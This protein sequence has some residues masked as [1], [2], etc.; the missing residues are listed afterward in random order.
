MRWNGRGGKG[1]TS[2]PQFPIAVHSSGRYL[3]QADGRPFLIIGESAWGLIVRLTE[4]QV[5][6]YIADRKSRGF[7]CAM[8]M[9]IAKHVFIQ[10]GSSTNQN[11]DNPFTGTALIPAN[12]NAAYFT[13]A[14]LVVR[15]FREAGMVL[16][17]A[18]CYSGFDGPSTTEGWWPDLTS[19]SVATNWGNWFGNRYKNEPHVIWLGGGDYTPAAGSETTRANALEQA[20]LDA[21]A[22]QLHT[23]HNSRGVG[24]YQKW[25]GLPSWLTLGNIYTDEGV[26]YPIHDEAATEYARSPAKP[27]FLIEDRYA[28]EGGISDSACI[29]QKWQAILSGACG[30]LIGTAAI[31]KFESGYSSEF[32]SVANQGMTHLK[33]LLVDSGYDWTTLVPKADTSLVSS[34]L[35]SGQTRICPALGGSG[36]FAMVIVPSNTNPTVVM[37]NFTPSSVR[38]RWYDITAGTFTTASGSPFANTGSQTITHPGNNAQGS[39]HWVLVMDAA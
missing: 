37:T 33:T 31:W 35:G 36:A 21:G 2:I 17:L 3:V 38:A 18:G 24:A 6:A 25:T 27:F 29:V 7:N 16:L 12:V 1:I 26:S 22:T 32:G 23:Y 11:G 13:Y 4:A 10:S 19:D 20:I 8:V 14:D 15:K 39:P 28:D 34:S 5:D 9:L 30:A